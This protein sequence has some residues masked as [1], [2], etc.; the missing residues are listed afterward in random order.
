MNGD[1]II[2]GGRRTG[3]ST[4]LINYAVRSM[5]NLGKDKGVIVSPTK[6]MSDYLF[7][8]T[9][10]SPKSCEL[11]KIYN[12]LTIYKQGVRY[13]ITFISLDEYGRKS[14]DKE[15]P[16]YFDEMDH[17]LKKVLPNF[18]GGAMTYP[19]VKLDS[20]WVKEYEEELKREMPE[21][22][23]MREFQADFRDKE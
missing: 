22:Q 15:T 21:E 16:C 4:Q 10:R 18:V 11:D 23:Y 12:I 14:W 2:I 6:A 17:I 8:Q 7:H 19:L 5:R 9:A 20:P 3:K 1:F 13:R